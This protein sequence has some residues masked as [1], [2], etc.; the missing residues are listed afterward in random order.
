MLVKKG[1]CKMFFKNTDILIN[2]PVLLIIS[3]V[4]CLQNLG[5]S[6]AGFAE[7]A[8]YIFTLREAK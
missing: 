8:M 4:A 2:S 5:S 6:M 1:Q 7:L 3:C